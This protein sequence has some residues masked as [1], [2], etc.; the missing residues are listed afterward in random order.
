MTPATPFELMQPAL[1]EIV[2]AISGLATLALDLTLLQ[3]RT[4]QTR[5]TVSVLIGIPGCIAGIL[6]LVL[7]PEHI[8][9]YDGMLVVNPLT[10]LVQRYWQHSPSCTLLL[11]PGSDFTTHVGEYVLL[12]L[13]ATAGMMFLASTQICWSSSSRSNC[14]AS[15]CTS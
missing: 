13:F 2:V 1:P 15:P 12:V 4:L 5:W 3:R 14:L 7:R 11:S 9:L 6:L 10:Q 8:T